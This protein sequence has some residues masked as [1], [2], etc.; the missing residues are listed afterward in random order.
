MDVAPFLCHSP[1]MLLHRGILALLPL[2]LL[3]ACATGADNSTSPTA[4][5]GGGGST[6]DGATDDGPIG[7]TTPFDVTSSDT[8]TPPGDTV[9][10]AHDRTTLYSVDPKDPL[11]ATTKVGDFDCIGDPPG[12]PGMTD[13]AV[14]KDGKVYGVSSKAIFL[15]MQIDAVGGTVF[16]EAGK[17]MIDVG[18]VGTAAKFFGMTFAP[19]TALLGATE[20]LIGANTIGDLYAIN[21]TTGSLTLVGRLGAVPSN[22]GQ[23]HSYDSAHVGQNWALSGDL[24]FMSNNGQPVGFATVRDCADPSKAPSGC[25]T[26]DTLVE[27][28]VAK[29]APTGSGVAPVVTKSIRG[30]ILPQGCADE[31]CGFGSMYGIAAF[32][33]KVVGFSYGGNVVSIN[34][35]TGLATLINTPLQMPGFAG[36]GVTTTVHVIPPTPK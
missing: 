10:Y 2:A 23:G 34:N 7:D 35:S 3:A 36:A 16:C 9:L 21:V 19:P 26:I 27:I 1:G 31:A 6:G 13:L 22:D 20:T 5:A 14:N 4:D 25:S 24:V 29:L 18:S 11:L 33:D 8:E 32:E 15:D 17:V 30:K 12:E 28:D